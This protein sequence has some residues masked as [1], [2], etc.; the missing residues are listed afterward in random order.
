MV[1]VS[2]AFVASVLVTFMTLGTRT[3]TLVVHGVLGTEWADMLEEAVTM[4][5]ASSGLEI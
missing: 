5:R 1:A 3:I 2:S 4:G